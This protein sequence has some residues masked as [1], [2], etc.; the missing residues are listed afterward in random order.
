MPARRNRHQF[1][2]NSDTHLG[3]SGLQV[4]PPIVPAQLI[5]KEETADLF[6]VQV[7]FS[8]SRAMDSVEVLDA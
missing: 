3:L 7:P 8:E 4:V 1:F 2:V 6:V 5:P